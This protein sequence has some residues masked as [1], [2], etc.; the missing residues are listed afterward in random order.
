MIINLDK[1]SRLPFEDSEFDLC[2]AFDVLEHLEKFHLINNE[3]LRVAKQY[4]LISLPNSAFEIYN[5][6]LKNNPQKRPDCNRGTFSKY[7]GLPI[8]EPDDRHR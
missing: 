2:C 6:V 4:V 5:N 3:L 7:Y 8:I 1:V